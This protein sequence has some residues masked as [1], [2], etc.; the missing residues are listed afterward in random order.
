MLHS[1]WLKAVSIHLKSKCISGLYCWKNWK[2]IFWKATT[3][4]MKPV[5][6]LTCIKRKRWLSCILTSILDL[7][8]VQHTGWLL[9]L[10]GF[11]E[12]L[13]GV[14]DPASD[15][16]LRKQYHHQPTLLRRRRLAA[17]THQQRTV[18]GVL[19]GK[20]QGNYFFL[21]RW[22]VPKLVDYFLWWISTNQGI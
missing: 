16:G 12:H 1:H 5:T 10:R 17:G 21:N 14:W 15:A 13:R 3:V 18:L 8:M 20:I 9:Q 11:Y 6:S 2:H 4:E 22:A 19:P 7:R